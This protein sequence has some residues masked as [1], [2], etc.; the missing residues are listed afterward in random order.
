MVAGPIERASIAERATVSGS[1]ARGLPPKNWAEAG[2]GRS[3]GRRRRTSA[4]AS[5][6]GFMSRLRWVAF[7]MCGREAGG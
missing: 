7:S 1:F 3:D 5:V 6:R 2:A 4:R